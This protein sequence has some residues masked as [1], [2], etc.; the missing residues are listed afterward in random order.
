MSNTNSVSQTEQR[1]A[2]EPGRDA[3]HHIGPTRSLASP[4]FWSRPARERAVTFA[5]L[6]RDEPV[7]FQPSSGFDDA[8]KRRGFWA[9]TRHAD[10]KQGVNGTATPVPASP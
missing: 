4:E 6:R 2:V 10:V 3:D 5:E 1:G 9:V 7:S 8:S